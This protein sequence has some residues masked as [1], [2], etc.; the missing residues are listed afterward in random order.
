MD[1]TFKKGDVVK[2]DNGKYQETFVVE[3]YHLYS[4]EYNIPSFKKSYCTK[5][6]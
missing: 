1:D 5:V 6:S 3:K 4:T 2:Y